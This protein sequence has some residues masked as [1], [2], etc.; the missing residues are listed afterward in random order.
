MTSDIQLSNEV[1]HT[2]SKLRAFMDTLVS[3][4]TLSNL[5]RWLGASVLIASVSMFLFKG[6]GSGNDIEK[7]LMLLAQTI[8][9]AIAGVAVGRWVK[10]SK[11]A[12]LFLGLSLISTV[13]NFAVLGGLMYSQIQWDG[14]LGEYPSFARWQAQSLSAA[15]V[16]AA[17][18]WIL[19]VPAAWFS[20]MTLARRSS[21]RLAFLFALSSSALLIPVRQAEIVAGLAAVLTAFLLYQVVRAKAK[22][23]SLAT[24]EGRFARLVLFSAPAILVGRGI[25]LYSAEI[26][27][28]TVIA[29]LAFIA[30]RQ[31]SM[32]HKFS[33]KA[34]NAINGL[35]VPPAIATAFGFA[36]TLLDGGWIG[37]SAWLP[38]FCVVLAAMLTDIAFRHRTNTAYLRIANLVL[39]TGMLANLYLFPMLSTAVIC[40]L[41][42]AAVTVYGHSFQKRIEFMMGLTAMLAGTLYQC[43]MAFQAFD[44]GSWSALAILGALAIIAASILDRHGSIIHARLSAWQQSIKKVEYS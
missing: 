15:L 1:P 31:L 9:L 8:F 32:V 7:Y 21:G 25:Y 16:T 30:I 36:I 2:P 5:L 23:A 24:R 10:E 38:V 11:G 12:R 6:W 13:V 37:D 27:M 33:D 4:A 17:G 29:G 41:G 18:A 43:Y 35:S 14:G 28:L 20:F 3:Y 39:A 40:L 26:M 22:D 19:L 34:R 42:G 44:L